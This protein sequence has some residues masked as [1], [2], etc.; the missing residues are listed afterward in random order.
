MKGTLAMLAAALAAVLAPIAT[1]CSGAGPGGPKLEAFDF[2]FQPA[3][4]AVAG[5]NQLTL[6]FANKGKEPHN[7]TIPAIG[8]D[9]DLQPGESINVIFIPPASGPLEFFCK[10]HK[11][12]GMVGT[13]Q[14]K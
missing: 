5:G 6:P 4:I 1:G 2:R 12:Q 8:A 13:F 10:F 11:S 14:V 9:L 3:T 7:I